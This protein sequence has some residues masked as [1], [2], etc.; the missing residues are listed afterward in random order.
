MEETFSD[1]RVIGI[2]KVCHQA[3][4]AWCETN[5]DLSQPDWDNAPDWQIVSACLGVR[6]HLENPDAGDDASHNSWMEQKIKEGWVYGE[7]KNPGLKTHPCIVPF[8]ELPL[9][10]QKKDALFRSIV[11]AL[12]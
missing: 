4:K 7:E 8:E 11:H 3:N 1:K 12:K 2:A 10:Q 6:F 5:G 9:V